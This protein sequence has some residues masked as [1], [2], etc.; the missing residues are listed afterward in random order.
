VQPTNSLVM[1]AAQRPPDEPF[2]FLSPDERERLLAHGSERR[3]AEGEPILN[4]RERS[5]AIYVLTNGRAVVKKDHLGLGVV[6]DELRPGAVFGEV[7][8]LDGSLTSASV[9]AREQADVLVLEGLEELLES[10]PA[11]ASGFYRSLATLLAG[12]LR[13]TTEENVTTALIWG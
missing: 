10:D 7:S 5:H 6:V 9:V 12:R 1:T 4:E 11:L 8:Y 13:F 2:P 3:Y